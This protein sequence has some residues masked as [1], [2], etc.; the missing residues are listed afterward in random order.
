MLTNPPLIKYSATE[1]K[2]FNASRSSNFREVKTLHCTVLFGIN[3]ND[4]GH[5]T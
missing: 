2:A 3:S 5:L 1:T 4:N